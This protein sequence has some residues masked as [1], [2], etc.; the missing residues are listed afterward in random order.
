MYNKILCAIFL[1]CTTLNAHPSRMTEIRG[2]KVELKTINHSMAGQINGLIVSG[3]KKNGRFESELTV[4]DRDKKFTS[5]FKRSQN[6]KLGG[7]ITI[8]ENGIHQSYHLELK[9]IDTNQNTFVYKVGDKEINV[10]VTADDFKDG[11]FINPEYT[12][13]INGETISFKIFDGQ[14]CYGYSSHLIAM[15]LSAY[16]FN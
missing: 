5:T 9:E 12:S 7:T 8:V 13:Q 16:L 3:L 2:T 14:A 10:F 15:I 1:I 11:H 6:G 4:I